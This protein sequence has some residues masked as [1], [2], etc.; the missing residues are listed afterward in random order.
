[1]LNTSCT[2]SVFNIV[3]WIYLSGRTYYYCVIVV[4]M[5]GLS[6]SKLSV[7]RGLSLEQLEMAI[8][9]LYP[10]IPLAMAGFILA[11]A[12]KGRHIQHFAGQTVDEL[13]AFIGKGKLIVIPKRD[14]L[15]PEPVELQKVMEYSGQ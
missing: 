15:I 11:R 6:N 14:V 1:M 8:V 5:T 3:G 13:E 12:D 2:E 4:F 9:N 7:L 10:R